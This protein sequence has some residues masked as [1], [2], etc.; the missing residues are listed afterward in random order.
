MAPLATISLT[1]GFLFHIDQHIAA[2]QFEEDRC[3]ARRHRFYLLPF[4]FR[5]HL[6]IGGQKDFVALFQ[7]HLR[8]AVA[9]SLTAQVLLSYDF[10]GWFIVSQSDE[11]RMP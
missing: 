8:R 2:S 7:E 6:P 1:S 9:P 11:L 3:R 10:S 4:K 5:V